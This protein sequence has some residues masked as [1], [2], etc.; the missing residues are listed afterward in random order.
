MTPPHD[1]RKTDFLT[2]HG[3]EG[4]SVFR[5]HG[6]REN[7]PASG[8]SIK[9]LQDWKSTPHWI[10]RGMGLPEVSRPIA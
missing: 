8:D 9:R 6:Q 1:D 7:W 5:S 3:V 4:G 2:I 10:V